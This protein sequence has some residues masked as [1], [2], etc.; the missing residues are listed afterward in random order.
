[1]Y[2]DFTQM[3]FFILWGI[4]V[5]LF[6][7]WFV[8]L[9][10]KKE[11]ITVLSSTVLMKIFIPLVLMYPFAF[12]EKNKVATG[13]SAY[14]QYLNEINKVFIISLIGIL[15]FVIGCYV[16]SK[17]KSEHH[18]LNNLSKAYYTFLNKKDLTLYF[19]CL[20]LIFLL[21]FKLGF[22]QSYFGGRSFAMEN[23]SLRPISNFFYSAGT[24]FLMLTLTL[25]YQEKSR[26]I[27]IYI[28]FALTMALTSGTRGAVLNS[29]MLFVFMYYNI[30]A[31]D[32]SRADLFKLLAGGLFLLTAAMYLGDARQQQYNLFVAIANAGDKILYGNNF[33]DLRDFAWVTSYWNSELQ[34]GKTI[35]SGYLSFIP[36]SLFPLRSQWGLGVFTV[37]TIGYDTSIHPGLRPGI[38]G[39]SYFNFGIIGVCVSGFLYGFIINMVNKYVQEIIHSSFSKR[40][41][42][43]KVSLGYIVSAAAF[44][45]MITAGFFN[46]Y[47]LVI[48]VS[49]GF[50][51][52]MW[53][54]KFNYKSK[55]RKKHRI[56]WQ[57]K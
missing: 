55:L 17:T 8:Y 6:F 2:F 39:E 35:I 41:I 20:I 12:S 11:V 57:T 33:S 29:I 40:E 26:L 27:L 28:I 14:N 48:I 47:V 15:F 31:K 49:V 30:N 5:I 9:Y 24:V 32:S 46:V 1:M 16:A 44:N 36:S 54:R 51:K 13:V 22:F 7:S 25:Y 45:F 53:R 38:F 10:F 4:V 21:M 3:L 34:Y 42:I 43:Y 37:T 19:S 56:I 23:T 18:L 52:Y 50:L